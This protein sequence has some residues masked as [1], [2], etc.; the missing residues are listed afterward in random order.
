MDGR[1]RNHPMYGA[2][3]TIALVGALAL[4]GQLAAD[5][6]RCGRVLLKTGDSVSTLR[7][8][9]GEPNGRD[10]GYANLRHVNG[11]KRTRV[12]RWRYRS[13]RGGLEK[14]VLIHEGAVVGIETGSRS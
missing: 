7:S 6:M 10:S 11:G 3:W 9:C 5:S 2:C 12:A 13:G 1:R 8:R 14:I 4:P